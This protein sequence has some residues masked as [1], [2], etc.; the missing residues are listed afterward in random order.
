M[1]K[2][3]SFYKNLHPTFTSKY[4]YKARWALNFSFAR[5]QD[6]AEESLLEIY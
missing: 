4:I 3:F 2:Y 5:Q 1:G 6:K